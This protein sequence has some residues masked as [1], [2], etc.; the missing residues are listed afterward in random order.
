MRGMQVLLESASTFGV[1]KASQPSTPELELD[2]QQ[3]RLLVFS[4]KHPEAL[5]RM[6]ED[7]ESYLSSHPEALQDLS[8]SLGMKRELLSYRAFCVTSGEDSFEMS[9]TNK[10]G[11]KA[12]PKLVF[13]FTGQGAQWAQMGKQLI[14]REPSFRR[15]IRALDGYLMLLPD[16]P[17]WTLEGGFLFFNR[18]V[19]CP[20]P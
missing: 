11:N 16:P 20:I 8:Y 3:Q 5:R 18:A 6:A 17:K 9:K 19:S 12:A 13:A 4:A 15:S 2:A 14:E 7:H 1:G 10:P